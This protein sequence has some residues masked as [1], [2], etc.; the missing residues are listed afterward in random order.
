MATTSEYMQFAL[1]VYNA[2]DNNKIGVPE[3]W[4]LIDW[5]PDTWT[6]FS[7]GVYKNNTNNEIGSQIGSGLEI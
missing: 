7:A 1:G 2:S 5:E 4:S 3:G 6:G